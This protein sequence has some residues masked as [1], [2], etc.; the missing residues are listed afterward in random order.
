MF[1]NSNTK[2][3]TKSKVVTP[4]P[5]SHALN[6]VVEG[7][8]FEGDIKSESDIRI[9]GKLIGSLHCDGKVIIGPKGSIEGD[10]KC[11]NALIEGGFNG[12]LSVS[13]TLTVNQTAK[14]KGDVST[15]KLVVHSGAEFNV[16]CSMGEAIRQ[17]KQSTFA[18][19]GPQKVSLDSSPKD[20]ILSFADSPI[21]KK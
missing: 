5:R 12:L 4:Q 6:S 17:K 20:E 14:I 7:T 15:D 19:K 11:Q 18:Q 16:S 8:V 13:D 9:D 21:K 10:I 1:G 3:E 2:K